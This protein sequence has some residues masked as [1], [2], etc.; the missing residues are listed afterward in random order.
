MAKKKQAPPPAPEK[1]PRQIAAANRIR[2]GGKFVNK[3]ASEAVKVIVKANGLKTDAATVNRFI[4]QNEKDIQRKVFG[5]KTDPMPMASSRATNLI[6]AA[7]NVYN[8]EGKKITPEDAKLQIAT[9][10]NLVKSNTN[11]A[12]LNLRL[13]GNTNGDVK[14]MS[15]L[16]QL[17]DTIEEA[18]ENGDSPEDFFSDIMDFLDDNEIEYFVSDEP[19]P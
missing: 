12:H 9:F 4:Q 19:A 17:I 13:G 18:A 14:L 11:I 15:D 8:S 3:A 2:I 7:K 16:Q 6:D 10:Y 5:W 1:T